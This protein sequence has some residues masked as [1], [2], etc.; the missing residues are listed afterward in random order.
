LRKIALAGRKNP[1][2]QELRAIGAV[3]LLGQTG[4]H[5]T[6]PFVKFLSAIVAVY[7]LG[8]GAVCG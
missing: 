2:R 3:S 6:A 1:W 5:Q 7:H 8:I 4:L